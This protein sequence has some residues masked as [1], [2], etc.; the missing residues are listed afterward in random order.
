[1]AASQ[2][3]VRHKQQH[4][5]VCHHSTLPEQLQH[6]QAERKAQAELM[7]QMVAQAQAL[8]AEKQVLQ[9]AAA[10]LEQEKAQ[11]EERLDFLL[12]AQQGVEVGDGGTARVDWQGLPHGANKKND[13]HILTQDWPEEENSIDST[14]SPGS[15]SRSSRDTGNCRAPG[16]P[17]AAA[18]LE[19]V[20]AALQG[21][22]EALADAEQWMWLNEACSPTLQQPGPVTA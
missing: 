1:M 10:A 22:L 9:S 16:T 20:T 21:T 12:G 15:G 6:L 19:G 2:R 8:L 3:L 5:A 11:L 4:H 14:L 7:D 18:P 17:T 13:Q